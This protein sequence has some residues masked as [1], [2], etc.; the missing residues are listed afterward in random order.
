MKTHT[1]SK[2]VNPIMTKKV[3]YLNFDTVFMT[4]DFLGL[5]FTCATIIRE[6]NFNLPIIILN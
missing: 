5:F 6:K 4:V 3:C 2:L 1:A